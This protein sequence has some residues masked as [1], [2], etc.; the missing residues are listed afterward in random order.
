MKPNTRIEHEPVRAA[1]ARNVRDEGGFS[2][3]EL[4]VAS[5]ISLFAAS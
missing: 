4:M 5:L 3:L 1:I 2:L